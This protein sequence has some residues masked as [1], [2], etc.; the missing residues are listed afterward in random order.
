MA[1]TAA[2]AR[3]SDG[4][5]GGDAGRTAIGWSAIPGWM[6]DDHLAAFQA[7][8]KTCAPIL[9]HT[10]ALRSARAP[11]P[12][13]PPV[14]RAALAADIKN[15][16]AARAFF[17]THFSAYTLQPANGRGFITGYYEPEVA[18][19]L[20]PTATFQWPLRARP[21]NLVTLTPENAIKTA[22]AELVAA[23]QTPEGLQ[24]V[25]DRA[26]IENGAL[27][28]AAK[29][30]V[31][32]RDETEALLIHVQGSTRI[33]LPDGTSIRLAYA[34]RNGYPFTST[35]RLIVQQHGLTPEDVTLEKLKA[36]LRA[37]GETARAL[38]RANR[39]YIF[40]RIAGELKSGDGP[41]GGAGVPLVP[42]R[43]LAVDRTLWFY[44]LPF[45]IRS[46]AHGPDDQPLA[47]LMIAQDTGSAILGPAR[48]DVFFGSGAAMGARAGIVRHAADFFVL[49]PK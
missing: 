13:M 14:C 11:W 44:G 19:S 41:I 30:L 49:L 32:V 15:N 1:S 10:E 47:R 48:G 28:D 24:P 7:F 43:S 37:H 22:D 34:G 9:D 2:H 17:E 40:F 45:F 36:W 23:L 3:E 35:A 33:I 29:P 39:S 27:G 16:A 6:A 12:Q 20:T 38:I 18:G 4:S 46:D 21:D 42:G 25:P 8:L 26:A 5:F 31:Y